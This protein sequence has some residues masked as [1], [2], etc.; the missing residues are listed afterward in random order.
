VCET[1]IAENVALATS[2]M[3]S[4]DVFEFAPNSLGAAHYREL[5]QEL[6]D[7]GFFV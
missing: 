6:W 1:R 7:G 3:H 4:K 2:P 5:T